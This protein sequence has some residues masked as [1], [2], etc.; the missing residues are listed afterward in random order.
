MYIDTRDMRHLERGLGDLSRNG[1]AFAQRNTINDLAFDTQRRARENIRNNYINR[2]TWTVRSVR[3]DKA[4]T[5]RDSAEVGST[6]RYMADQEFGAV[7]HT[8]TNIATR[9]ASGEGT[10]TGVRR[11]V[12]RRAN[13]MDRIARQVKRNKNMSSQAITNYVALKEA[14]ADGRKFVYQ[15][16]GKRKGIY[17]V[18]GTK[19]KPKSRMVQDLSRKVAVVPKREWLGPTAEGMARRVEQFHSNNLNKEVVRAMAKLQGA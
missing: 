8:N 11:R 12:V 10:G 9:A 18:F 16:R 7:R 14:K 6:E 4:R 1:V 5:T 13:R 2:N 17:K 15:S 19:R 3:V